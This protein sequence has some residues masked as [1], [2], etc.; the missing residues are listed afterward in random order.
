MKVLVTGGTGVVG[1]AAVR[2]LLAA[3]HSVRL[4]SRHA[5]EDAARWGDEVETHEGSISSTAV[6]H[7]DGSRRSS[8]SVQCTSS[9]VEY[10]NP[11]RRMAAERRSRW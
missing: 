8:S 5:A 1:T 10:G 9:S 11:S 6:S 2:A 3:G 4:F 7:S